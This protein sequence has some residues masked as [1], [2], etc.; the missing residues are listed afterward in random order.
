MIRQNIRPTNGRAP[1]KDARSK[2][3]NVCVGMIDDMKNMLAMDLPGRYP[4]TSASGN[5][6]VFIMLD[7]DTN[8]IRAIPMKSRETGE[9]IRCYTACYDYFKSRGFTS[10]LI[11]LDNEVSTKLI[12][13]I[14][15][16]N[17]DYQLAAP[18]DHRRN[19]A[20]RA[21]QSFKDHF[22][23]IRAGTDCEF[24]KD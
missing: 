3:H 18:G 13:Q 17:L 2:I 23:S 5:K 16:D 22:I 12:K 10:K 4:I 20:E 15:L 21:I 19:P 1:N 14:Q 24:P 11:R 7:C 6:Y 8:Y 9:M